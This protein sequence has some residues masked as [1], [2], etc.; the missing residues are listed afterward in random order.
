ML[1][2]K[3]V[4]TKARKLPTQL[5]TSKIYVLCTESIKAVKS[6]SAIQESNREKGVDYR[7]K[8]I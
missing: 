5:S 7:T 8:N 2:S 3:G 1:L 6:F 4:T